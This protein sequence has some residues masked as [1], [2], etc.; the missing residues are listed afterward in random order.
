M[1]IQING[2]ALAL[3]GITAAIVQGGFVRPLIGRFGE[4]GTVVLGLTVNAIAFLCYGLATDGWMIPCI[5]VFGALGGTAGP[6]IQSIVAG[7]VSP[8]EQ[9]KVQG[10]LTSLMSLT[11]IAAPLI[12]TAGLF[13]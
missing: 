10:A 5:I 1:T 3:V 4:R 8:S 9:G 11:S 2:Y 6:A 12:F 7:A 13:D